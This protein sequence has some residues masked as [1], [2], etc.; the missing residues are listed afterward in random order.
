[1]SVVPANARRGHC[2]LQ[3]RHQ[4]VVSCLMRELETELCP[5]QLPYSLL[6]AKPFISP[7]PR[8]IPLETVSIPM[9]SQMGTQLFREQV[10]IWK[11]GKR[12]SSILTSERATVKDSHQP[13]PAFLRRYTFM[14]LSRLQYIFVCDARKRILLHSLHA[15]IYILE[16]Y[17]CPIGWSWYPCC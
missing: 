3:N 4:S 15:C 11:I 12:E 16:S 7:A 5:L 10:A 9:I 6:T 17:S 13:F 14:P 1:M 8:A 2:M